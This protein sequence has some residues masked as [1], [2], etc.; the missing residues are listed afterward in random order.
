MMCNRL[1][2]LCYMARDVAARSITFTRT[3]HLSSRVVVQRGGY[4]QY[5]QFIV[6]PASSDGRSASQLLHFFQRVDRFL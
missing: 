2:L 6:S 4:D 1:N 3:I 5:R